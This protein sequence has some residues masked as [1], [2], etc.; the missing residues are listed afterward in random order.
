MPGLSELLPQFP[1]ARGTVVYTDAHRARPP[2]PASGEYVDEIRS[3]GGQPSILAHAR[4]TIQ[5]EV[6]CQFGSVNP[7]ERGTLRKYRALRTVSSLKSSHAGNI[8][9]GRELRQLAR[10]TSTLNMLRQMT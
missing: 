5:H 3:S 9:R 10:N 7:R 2:I 1:R 8:R 4:N 6:A